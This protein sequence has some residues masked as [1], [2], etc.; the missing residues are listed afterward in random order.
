MSAE[1]LEVPIAD[2]TMT[3]NDIN[4]RTKRM[5]RLEREK[6]EKEKFCEQK[7]KKPRASAGC[8]RSDRLSSLAKCRW[9]QQVPAPQDS[10][11][12]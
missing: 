11:S 5:T 7:G 6:D 1:T 10:L 2:F 3:E 4:H 8:L 9:L 12:L